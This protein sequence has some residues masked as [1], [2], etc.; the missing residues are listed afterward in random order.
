MKLP[1]FV[2]KVSGGRYRAQR[3]IDGRR[4]YGP[5]RQTAAQAYADAVAW[6]AG[7]A[8]PR[9]T[10]TLEQA[11]AATRAELVEHRSAGTVRFF[12]HHARVLVGAWMPGAPL[13]L[14]TTADIEAFAAR[15]ARD[16]KQQTVLHDLRTLSRI[17]G[18]ARRRGWID[19]DPL[20]KVVMPRAKRPGRIV[21]FTPAEVGSIVQRIRSDSE[22]DADLI[23][24]AF[25]TGLRRAEIGRLRAEDVDL[26]GGR[27]HVQGKTAPRELPIGDELREVLARMLLR[28]PAGGPLFAGGFE[29][30]AHVFWKW[31]RRLKEPRLRPHLARHTFG[32]TLA[33][34]G[35]APHTIAAL[36]GHASL[37]MAMRYLHPHSDELRHAMGKVTARGTRA[38]GVTR[39]EE[40]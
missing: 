20:K 25:L 4:R 2:K 17:L 1:P 40:A 31:Q 24:L 38:G 11:V 13:H 28:V 18:V 22:A 26:R 14:I 7:A 19:G 34:A 36:M 39:A 8:A 37:R 3:Q 10:Y 21:T 23:A 35:V 9:I 27:V 29:R 30:V 33:S 12:D 32:S 15:R 5:R 6:E 16:V